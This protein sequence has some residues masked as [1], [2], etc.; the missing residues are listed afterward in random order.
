MKPFT[1]L[2]FLLCKIISVFYLLLND[3]GDYLLLLFFNNNTKNN[4]K[5]TENAEQYVY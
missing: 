5:E 3:D 1:Y 4:N 2:T